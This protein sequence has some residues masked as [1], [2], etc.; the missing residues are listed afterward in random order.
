MAETVT[1]TA[2]VTETVVETE[3]D[4]A[5]VRRPRSDG[6]GLGPTAS[7]TVSATVSATVMLPALRLRLRW[8][9]GRLSTIG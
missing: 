7:V 3:T 4:A 1:E 2:A 8:P 9:I 6:L 5:S